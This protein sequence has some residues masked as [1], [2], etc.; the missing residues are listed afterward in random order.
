M[1]SEKLKPI[2]DYQC[3][4]IPRIGESWTWGMQYRVKDVHWIHWGKLAEQWHVKVY[5]KEALK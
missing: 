2:I 3:D 1:T 5:V 4:Y